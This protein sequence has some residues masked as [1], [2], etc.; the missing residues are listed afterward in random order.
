MSYMSYKSYTSY[1]PHTSYMSYTVYM[2]YNTYM[3]Y[4]D[5]KSYQ[6]AVII[7]D[8]TA[9]FVKKHISQFSRTVEQMIQ[10]ARSGVQNIVEGPEQKNTGK[11]EHYLLGVARG[12][13]KELQQDYE[14]ILRQQK[15]TL[16][17]KDDQRA[18][19]VRQMAYTS[20]RSYMTYKAYMD[21]K[22]GACNVM[23]CLINQT[24]YLIDQQRKA[25]EK[26]MLDKGMLMESHA[27]KV[28]R[29]ARA[30][31]EKLR[32]FAEEAKRAADEA[33]AKMFGKI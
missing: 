5:L 22:E 31:A 24:T 8:F 6:N 28:R 32:P 16:W 12:S 18:L 1:K 20:N 2:S 26:Q 4:R 17:G 19:A 9:E 11:S 23:I 33:A 30:E 27:Q 29:I 10:A 25:L 3:S 7:H 13:L 21:T 14:D 15:L